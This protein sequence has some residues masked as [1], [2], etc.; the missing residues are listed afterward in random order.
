MAPT[1]FYGVNVVRCAK[2]GELVLVFSGLVYVSLN[3]L[4][5]SF[6]GSML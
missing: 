5:G 6:H 3:V 4:R 2:L 1:D